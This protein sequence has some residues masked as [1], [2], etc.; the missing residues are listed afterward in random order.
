MP[1]PYGEV[2]GGHGA[3]ARPGMRD[4]LQWTRA[5]AHHAVADGRS[6][7]QTLV[8]TVATPEERTTAAACAAVA[9]HVSGQYVAGPRVT[10]TDEPRLL[11]TVRLH[12]LRAPHGSLP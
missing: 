7:P 9:G 8:T 3:A 6:Q 5:G 1:S 11:V 4:V 10:V 12:E 2:G